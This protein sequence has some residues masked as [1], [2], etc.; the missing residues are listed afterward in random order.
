[1]HNRL[2]GRLPTLDEHNRQKM[3]QEAM[4][5]RP[6]AGVACPTCKDVEMILDGFRDHPNGTKSVICPKCKHRGV[7]R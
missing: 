7:M 5:N 6:P 1:M 2:M 4:A 3:I